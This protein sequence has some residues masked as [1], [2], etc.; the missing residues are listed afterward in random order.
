MFSIDKSKHKVSSI[1]DSRSQ[2]EI[3]PPYQ[4]PG[5]NSK[6]GIGSGVTLGEAIGVIVANHNPLPDA[7][8]ATTE[9][10]VSGV[11]AKDIIWARCGNML[12]TVGDESPCSTP[13]DRS[14]V[15]LVSSINPTH[16]SFPTINHLET[17]SHHLPASF[18]W[19]L[20]LIDVVATVCPPN[21]AVARGRDVN[22]PPSNSPPASTAV[23]RADIY[24][25]IAIDAPNKFIVHIELDQ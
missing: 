18:A 7:R 15:Q 6:E 9:S 22:Q 19:F 4:S 17:S 12:E 13:I 23:N 8:L 1:V 20:A 14:A 2:W 10:L 21:I 25:I 11:D 16:L 5:I 24:V 3:F